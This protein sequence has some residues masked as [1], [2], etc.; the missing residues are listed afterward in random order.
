M[1]IHVFDRVV[2]KCV[3]RI[4]DRFT[5]L[6]PLLLCILLFVLEL[7]DLFQG[8]TPSTKAQK[9]IHLVASKSL[10]SNIIRIITRPK[11]LA[12]HIILR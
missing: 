6:A 7:D 2:I 9:C 12:I 10:I 8:N 4:L 11:E 5:D 1:V 3:M